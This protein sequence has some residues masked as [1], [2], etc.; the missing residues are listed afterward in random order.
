MFKK[1]LKTSIAEVNSDRLRFLNLLDLK[2]V[3]L[4]KLTNKWAPL[5]NQT[6]IRQLKIRYP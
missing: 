5:C 6:P 3:G 4:S 1:T 2:T